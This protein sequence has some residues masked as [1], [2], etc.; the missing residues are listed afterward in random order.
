MTPIEL[1][2]LSMDEIQRILFPDLKLPESLLGQRANRKNKLALVN[3]Y[4]EI[5]DRLGLDYSCLV[6]S[7]SYRTH[8]LHVDIIPHKEDPYFSYQLE[9]ITIDIV[10]ESDKLWKKLWKKILK[11]LTFPLR[12]FSWK[13]KRSKKK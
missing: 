12:G 3:H 9:H 11:L 4:K 5:Y 6:T 10:F 1:I 2:P 8:T 7:F 13:L